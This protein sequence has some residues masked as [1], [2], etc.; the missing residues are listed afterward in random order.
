MRASACAVLGTRH[1]RRSSRSGFVPSVVSCSVW[2]GILASSVAVEA[3]ATQRYP[4]KPSVPAMAGGAAPLAAAAVL[5]PGAVTRMVGTAL[6]PATPCVANMREPSRRAMTGR[7]APAP[8]RLRRSRTST[9][10]TMPMMFR[11]L[12]MGFPCANRRGIA[13]AS[14]SWPRQTRPTSPALPWPSTA[15]GCER[16]AGTAGSPGCSN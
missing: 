2:S 16:Q 9:I 11:R 1:G 12:N 6:V 13:P 3:A 5:S 8:Y 4:Q 15:A 7:R 10:I 14:R